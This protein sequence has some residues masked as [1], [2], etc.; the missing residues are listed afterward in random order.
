MSIQC[1]NKSENRSEICV[2]VPKK[3]QSANLLFLKMY[4]K[5]L[6]IIIYFERGIFSDPELCTQKQLVR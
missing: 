3:E 1:E 4:C 5:G 6:K 2:I